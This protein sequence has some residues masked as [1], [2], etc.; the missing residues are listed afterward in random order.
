MTEPISEINVLKLR[1][2]DTQKVFA[3]VKYLNKIGHDS[4][5]HVSTVSAG[6]QLS[7]A[8][9]DPAEP[10][11]RIVERSLECT[12]KIAKTFKDFQMFKQFN[13]LQTYPFTLSALILES[14]ELV[15]FKHTGKQ[16]TID[17][18][19]ETA[20]F[21]I[22]ADYSQLLQVL[23]HALENSIE[24]S[25]IH[26]KISILVQKEKLDSKSGVSIEINDSGKGLSEIIKVQLF[27]PFATTKMNNSSGLGLYLI[28][29]IVQEHGGSV[30][31]E[32]DSTGTKMKIFLPV[33]E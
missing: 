5:N 21:K 10:L 11:Y 17:F 1:L 29:S 3:L 32:S 18:S 19:A 23:F 16:I 14:I 15:T 8:K 24:A 9:I 25:E 20:D 13:K 6:L 26:G 12:N 28:N 2:I 4:N 27:Q 7:K 33:K 30:T 22:N 31:L